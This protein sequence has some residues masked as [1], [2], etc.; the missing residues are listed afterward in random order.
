MRLLELASHC[1]VLTVE[2]EHVKADAMEEVQKRTG[3]RSSLPSFSGP[4]TSERRHLYP[5]R[6]SCVFARAR[7]YI[8]LPPKSP[9]MTTRTHSLAHN[10]RRDSSTP[11]RAPSGLSRTITGRKFTS[12]RTRKYTPDTHMHILSLL[13]MHPPLPTPVLSHLTHAGQLL[14]RPHR[15]T[16]NTQGFLSTLLLAPSGLSKT[17][18]GRR[19]TSAR[20]T[21]PWRTLWR[22]RTRQT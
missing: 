1:D 12:A 7:T 19:C 15:Q 20:T 16:P 11:R 18:T 10:N 17:S 6:S 14:T 9:P 4:K 2:I 13:L 5:S 21:S 3:T 8:T 22:A